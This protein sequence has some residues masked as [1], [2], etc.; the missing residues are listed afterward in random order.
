MYMELFFIYV[1]NNFV[2]LLRDVNFKLRVK[3]DVIK[4]VIFI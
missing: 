4:I 2:F 3:F 1:V